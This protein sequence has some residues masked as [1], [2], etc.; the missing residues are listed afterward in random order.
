MV[1]TRNEDDDAILVRAAARAGR[2]GGE[3]EKGGESLTPGCGI[4]F[5]LTDFNISSQIKP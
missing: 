1:S 2:V 3:Q 4:F 5:F